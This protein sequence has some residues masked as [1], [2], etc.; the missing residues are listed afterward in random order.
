MV[1]RVTPLFND[2]PRC[3]ADESGGNDD[4]AAPRKRHGGI[5]TGDGRSNRSRPVRRPRESVLGEPLVDVGPIVLD[6][7]LDELDDQTLDL[8]AD[9][10]DLDGGLATHLDLGAAGRGTP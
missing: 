4:A 1:A 2:L 10:G 9:D 7:V 5:G 8:S 3:V 6:D